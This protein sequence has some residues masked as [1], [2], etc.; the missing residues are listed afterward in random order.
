MFNWNQIPASLR[1]EFNAAPH[2]V[3][4]A[5]LRDAVALTARRVFPT[6]R[7]SCACS[8]ARAAA[9]PAAPLPPSVTERLRAT[10]AV[11][12]VAPIAP[13]PPTRITRVAAPAPRPLGLDRLNQRIRALLVGGS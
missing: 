7:T 9:R 11:V 8:T 10:T 1:A 3:R 13:P 4:T 5:V 6:A 2:D 12:A